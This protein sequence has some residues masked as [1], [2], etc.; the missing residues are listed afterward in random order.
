MTVSRFAPDSAGAS[1]L[2]RR[3]VH[4]VG[5]RIAERA[6]QDLPRGRRAETGQTVGALLAATRRG[7]P[8]SLTALTRKGPI[9]VIAPHPDDETIGCGGVLA[10][11]ADAGI[12][13]HV[14]VLTD[15]GFSHP[16]SASGARRL[17]QRRTEETVRA[18][19]RLGHAPGALTQFDLTDSRA[20][21]D[22]AGMRRAARRIARFARTIDAKALFTAW[23]H[24]PHPDH[25]AAALVAERVR[26][27]VPRL[28]L[29]H[30]P[31]RGRFLAQDIA[32]RD[33][34]WTGMR[35]DAGPWLARKR[36]AMAAYRTQTT[37]T[38][39][40]AGIEFRFNKG[41]VAPYLSRFELFFTQD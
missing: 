15:G 32:L 41:E 31:V 9:I 37:P 28:R 24:D 40:G 22:R 14:F 20:L 18:L 17:S 19:R 21:F 25:M 34:G 5:R 3:L 13:A 7:K 36:A 27:F 2:T 23:A 35:F 33:G 26:A 6:N 10:A 1:R 8:V 39:G 29:L 16:K 12:E 11:C 4:F 30:Y 38:M